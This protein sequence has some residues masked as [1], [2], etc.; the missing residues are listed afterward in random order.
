MQKLFGWN[1][2]E[3]EASIR[4]LDFDK[5][6][7]I[8]CQ[9]IIHLFDWEV[10][11]ERELFFKILEFSSVEGGWFSP[12]EVA[13]FLTDNFADVFWALLHL[14]HL[15][16]L[17]ISLKVNLPFTKFHGCIMSMEEVKKNFVDNRAVDGNG[18]SV[19]WE[20]VCS[21]LFRLN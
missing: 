15:D 11:S 14:Q 2:A 4:E 5:V 13:S 18:N 7:K 6:R 1:R 21:P 3:W 8:R 12:S 20:D 16:I 10:D 17:E 19:D 9:N